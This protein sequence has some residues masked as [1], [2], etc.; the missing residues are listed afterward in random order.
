M[1]HTPGPWNVVEG[2]TCYHVKLPEN[3]F[4]VG[5]RIHLTYRVRAVFLD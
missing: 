4:A 3:E 1:S 5:R 2:S